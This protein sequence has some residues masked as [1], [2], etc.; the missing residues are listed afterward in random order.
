MI[1]PDI[2]PAFA[3]LTARLTAKAQALAEARAE[4]KALARRSSPQRW[5]K[6]RL[7]WPLFTKG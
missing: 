1:T 7:L 6:A 4:T 3:A 5:R 2:G